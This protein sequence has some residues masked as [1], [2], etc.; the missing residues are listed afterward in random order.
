MA[1]KE[2]KVLDEEGVAGLVLEAF[3]SHSVLVFCDSKKRCENVAGLLVNVIQ[4]DLEVVEKVREV[5]QKERSALLA[6]ISSLTS[7]FICPTLQ[8]TIPFGIAYHHS[9]LTADERKVIEEGFLEGSL[10]VLA[11]TSTLAAGVNLP[12]RRVILRSPFMGRNL[13]THGQYKQMVGRAGRAG[14]DTFG[15]SFLMLK[16]TGR[17]KTIANDVVASPVEHC[18]SSLHNSEGRGLPNLILNCLH[19]GLVTTPGQV[20][21]LL[22]LSLLAAQGSK[23]S[24]EV[25]KLAGAALQGLLSRSLVVPSEEGDAT[26]QIVDSTTVI[27]PSRLGRAVVAGNIDLG[28]TEQLYRDL[29]DARPGLAVDTSL[30]LLFLITPY[31]LADQVFYDPATFHHI[32]L[33]LKPAEVAVCRGLGVTEC[34]MVKL[35]C[36]GSIKKALKPILS[37]LYCA[38][39]LLALWQADPVHE[40]AQ[41]FQVD[42]PSVPYISIL[43]PLIPS[44]KEQIPV[45]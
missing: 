24:V 39:I 5:K 13:L 20:N 29:K 21:Q 27:K 41:R 23:L 32:F 19:L 2:A 37:R 8:R 34:V 15:E 33:A 17:V 28:W 31:D 45:C 14:L 43:C 35:L 18:I 38:L 12:A 30:H 16:E 6:S 11:C 4:L 10:G 9:G 44:C 40:V 3:P 42:L 7:G 26:Q 1:T 25:S 22:S 36:G